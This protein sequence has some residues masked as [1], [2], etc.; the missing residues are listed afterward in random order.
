MAEFSDLGQPGSPGMD[1]NFDYIDFGA[2]PGEQYMMADFFDPLLIWPINTSSSATTT[3]SSQGDSDVQGL[4]HADNSPPT[5]E[6]S[7]VRA[8]STNPAEET[9]NITENGVTGQEQY[10]GQLHF[11][12]QQQ[13]QQQHIY[14][15]SPAPSNKATPATERPSKRR[16]HR[17]SRTGCGTCKKRRVKCDEVR[18]RCGNC[19]HLGLTCSFQTAGS[20]LLNQTAIARTG[21]GVSGSLRSGHSSGLRGM[22][23]GV[24]QPSDNATFSAMAANAIAGS[25]SMLGLDTSVIT[26]NV[27][28]L[29]LMHVYT[30]TV[31][32]TIIRVSETQADLWQRWVPE[33]AFQHAALMH[34]LLAFSG[35]YVVRRADAAVGALISE[36]VA[37]HRSEALRILRTVLQSQLNPEMADPAF[38]TGYLLMLDSIAN[39]PTI[40]GAKMDN[41]PTTHTSTQFLTAT[42]WVHLIRGICCILKSVWPIQPSSHMCSVLINDFH[43]LPFPRSKLDYNAFVKDLQPFS[44]R[45][46]LVISA[47][48]HILANATGFPL[49]RTA[50][51]NE[52]I[53]HDEDDLADIYPLASTSPYVIPCFMLT[54]FKSV[55]VSGRRRVV[56][57]LCIALG[58]LEDRFYVKF[59]SND[60]IAHRLIAEQYR[61]LKQFAK[62]NCKDVWWLENLADGLDIEITPSSNS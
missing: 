15:P 42:P 51:E 44:V 36:R 12:S 31:N 30:T 46:N 18:P 33:L 14:G 2:P 52:W 61:A 5:S 25:S 45:K 58:L 35:S 60:A 34:A 40:T 16:P 11:M 57:L 38:L 6:L 19:S 49:N 1:F 54:K 27:E 56:A 39:A 21:V 17:K 53:Y 28:D 24:M 29:R 23:L 37:V 4:T 20:M 47:K 43:D 48:Q 50:A 62:C 9:V 26:F 41:L 13:Q 8:S 55:L 22:N 32:L 59:H 10:T 3:S 7:T